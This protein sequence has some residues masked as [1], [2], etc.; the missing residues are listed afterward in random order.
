M[1]KNH[2]SSFLFCAAATA[3]LI[4]GMAL[5]ADSQVEI[6]KTNFPDDRFRTYLS[7]KFDDNKDGKLSSDE[8]KK[9]KRLRI[10]DIQLKNFKGIEFLTDLE[11]L[12]CSDNY[13][14]TI[15]LSKN[16]KL[17]VL[18]IDGNDLDK[19][20][21][22]KNTEL[23]YLYCWSNN[24]KTLDLSKNT[25]LKYLV[26]SDNKL[27]KIDLS[28]NTELIKLGCGGNLFETLDLSNNTK[29]KDLNVENSKLK[30]LDLSKNTKLEDLSIKNNKF[31]TLDLSKNKKIC[32]LILSNNNFE[33]LDLSHCPYV[34]QLFCDGNQIDELDISGQENLIQAFRGAKNVKEGYVIYW[35]EGGDTYDCYLCIDNKTSVVTD[36]QITVDDNTKQKYLNQG[37]TVPLRFKGADG[38]SQVTL[39]SADDSVVKIGSNNTLITGKAGSSDITAKVGNK[40]Y[41][42]KVTVYFKDVKDDTDFWFKPTYALTE[43][44]VVKGYGNQTSFK[45]GNKCTRAQMVTFIWRLMGSPE[46]KIKD[47]C[48]SDVK[49]GD[50]FY[51]ACLWGNENHIVEGYEDGTFG[52]QNVCTRKQAVTFL[53][54]LAGEPEPRTSKCKFNDVKSGEYYYKAV[55]WASEKKIVVGYDDNTFRP[56]GA[57]LRRQIVTFLYKYDK[58]V[59]NK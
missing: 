36:A 9:I 1:F 18:H 26:I 55:L 44:G 17:S 41:K 51:K 35:S 49:K 34:Y 50:Y 19:L 15:D 14:T 45:P 16:T 24:L 57:C 53:W 6:N 13:L 52:P 56:D 21:L 33:E 39:N 20:D 29:L 38:Q 11:W 32:S 42:F 28:K 22:S 54:R 59:N 8:I 43:K 12:F 23:E 46:P 2:L 48:F 5:N 25:K 3:I 47:C 58:Y 40:T 27:E 4:P 37:V 30:T 31:K 10:E 7:N